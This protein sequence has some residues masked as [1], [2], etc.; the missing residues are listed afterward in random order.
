VNVVEDD[1]FLGFEVAKESAPGDADFVGYL[2]DRCRL[3]TLLKK[4]G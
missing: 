4:K 3:E 2:I 1:T